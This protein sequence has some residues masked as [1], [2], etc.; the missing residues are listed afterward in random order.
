MRSFSIHSANKR[1][2]ELKAAAESFPLQWP[3]LSNVYHNGYH[4]QVR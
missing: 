4:S 2:G 3:G 1:A